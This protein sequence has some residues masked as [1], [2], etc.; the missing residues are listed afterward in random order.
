MRESKKKTVNWQ[1][2]LKQKWRKTIYT[3]FLFYARCVTGKVG[4]NKK[5]PWERQINKKR[6][7]KGR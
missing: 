5:Y 2:A 6:P 7:G 3:Q 1:E 4:V